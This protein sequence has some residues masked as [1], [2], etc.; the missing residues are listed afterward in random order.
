MSSGSEDVYGDT[1]ST[2]L[3]YCAEWKTGEIKWV[4]T[5]PESKGRG[6]VALT[7]ADGHLYLL[8]ANGYC[9]DMDPH[10]AFGETVTVWVNVRDPA[11]DRPAVSTSV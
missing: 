4:R 8:Y 5:L 11:P 6:S 1:D 2:G 3:I 10:T 9:K 7:Y